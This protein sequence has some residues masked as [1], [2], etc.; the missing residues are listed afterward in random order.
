MNYE[1]IK[2]VHRLSK[3]GKYY[4]HQTILTDIKP[5]SYV[6][7]VKTKP[8]EETLPKTVIDEIVENMNYS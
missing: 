4:I 2:F 6:D 5:V 7:K 3:C 1:P 8:D